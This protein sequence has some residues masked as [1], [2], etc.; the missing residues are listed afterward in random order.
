MLKEADFHSTQLK[1]THFDICE[2]T[3]ISFTGTSLK[4]IDLSSCHF[5]QI[6][7]DLDN[8]EGAIVNKE[9]AL[10]FLQLLGLKVKDA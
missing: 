2:L 10:G 5:E 8:V 3:G 4:G 7:V 9:Q 6:T 1:E